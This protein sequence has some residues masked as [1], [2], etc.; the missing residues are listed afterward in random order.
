MRSVSSL[1]ELSHTV[2]L[3]LGWDEDGKIKGYMLS[4]TVLIMPVILKALIVKA[5]FGLC[6][7]I[8]LAISGIQSPNIGATN[9]QG[10]LK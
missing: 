8:R 4:P 2:K 1:D 7:C 3:W 6:A 5:T 9:I 10:W